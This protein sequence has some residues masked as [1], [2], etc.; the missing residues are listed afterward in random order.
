[1]T[2]MS[3]EEAAEEILIGPYIVCLR[4]AFNIFAW[5]RGNYRLACLV[6]TLDLTEQLQRHKISLPSSLDHMVLQT[7]RPR[8]PAMHVHDE[9]TLTFETKDDEDR[10]S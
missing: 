10:S 8:Y 4:Y 3:K 9:I 6:L 7:W 2:W 1:M 5:L